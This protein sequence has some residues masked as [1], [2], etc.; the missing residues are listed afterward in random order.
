MDTVTAETG[1]WQTGS[2]GIGIDRQDASLAPGPRQGV[3]M[4]DRRPLP[5]LTLICIL[6]ASILAT[7]LV[8]PAG[9]A[10]WRDDN[11]QVLY[12]D[13]HEF[14]QQGRMILTFEHASGWDYGDNF[15]FFDVYDPFANSTEIYGEWHPRFDLDKISGRDLGFGPVEN[16]LIATELNVGQSWRAYLYGLGFDLEL[17]HF[18]F[19]SLNIYVRDDMTIDGDSTFQITPSWNLPFTLG[20]TAWEFRG[21]LDYAGA[22]GRGKA[23]LLAQPQLLLDVSRFW[24]DAGSL[25]AGVEY[26]YWKNKY[27]ADGIDESFAQVMARWVF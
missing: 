2:I 20:E 12:G 5:I 1:P 11:L 23:N 25:W 8:A 14:G 26:Q 13:G 16:V 18:Q 10:I 27:G 24:G 7:S 22:E 17:P 6:A 15:F 19:F 4:F 3:T 9:A 21:F